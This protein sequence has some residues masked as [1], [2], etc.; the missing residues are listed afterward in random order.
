MEIDAHAL[1]RDFLV[2]LLTPAILEWPG[3]FCRLCVLHGVCCFTRTALC[4]VRLAPNHERI[5]LIAV[6][7]S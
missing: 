6:P 5:D 4:F 3:T 7:W 2:D 1:A